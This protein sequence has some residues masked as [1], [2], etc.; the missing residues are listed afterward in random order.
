MILLLISSLPLFSQFNS[1]PRYVKRSTA[2]KQQLHATKLHGLLLESEGDTTMYLV[3]VSLV[4]RPTFL[5]SLSNSRSNSFR[6]FSHLLNMRIS[7]AYPTIC[8]VRLARL[9]FG[10]IL[11]IALWSTRLKRI[12]GTLLQFYPHE[13]TNSFSRCFLQDRRVISSGTEDSTTAR[14]RLYSRGISWISWAR[15]IPILLEP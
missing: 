14:N 12:A 11:P 9:P 8:E 1:T 5:F 6:A 7:S 4:S 15:S 3:L 13:N 10:T 2:S